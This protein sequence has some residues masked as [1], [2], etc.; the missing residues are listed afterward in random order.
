MKA[1]AKLLAVGLVLAFGASASAADYKC[2]GDSVEKSGSTQYKVRTSGADY[3][4][5]KSGSTKGKAVKRGSKYYVEV[6]GS[7]QATIEN[8][9]IYKSGSTWA[10]VSDAQ[11][12]Y[13]CPDVV[14]ATLWVLQQKGKL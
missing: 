4:I 1:L 6:S 9:K 5:E 12:I 14:A 13:D 10:S 8:G 3:T 2:R 7:T 11:R